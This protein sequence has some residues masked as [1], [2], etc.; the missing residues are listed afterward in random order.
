MCM[1]MI[2]GIPPDKFGTIGGLL[3]LAE[4]KQRERPH[5]VC[6]EH[7]RIEWAEMGRDIS[8]VYRASGITGLACTNARDSER[9]HSWDL[10]EWID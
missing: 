4:P 8:C 5:P 3:N 6:P 1:D 2:A 10:N 7:H 9:M